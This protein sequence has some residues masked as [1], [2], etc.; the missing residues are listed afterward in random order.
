MDD[1]VTTRPSHYRRGGYECRD[2]EAALLS[3]TG[4]PPMVAHLW[5][6]AFEYLWRWDLKGG[7]EDLRKAR[8]CVDE[9][10]GMVGGADGRT[11]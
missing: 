8:R 7:A 9:M 10:L 6:D 3:D 5:A 4:V 2:V 11:D 1:D